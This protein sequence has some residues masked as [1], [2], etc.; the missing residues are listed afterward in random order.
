MAVSTQKTLVGWKAIAGYFSRDERTVM[1]WAASRGMPVQR[2]AGQARSSVYA[3]PDDLD[4]WLGRPQSTPVPDM[5]P[6]LPANLPTIEPPAA[7]PSA[8][9][10]LHLYLRR[11]TLLIVLLVCSI[12]V[13][14]AA[15]AIIRQQAVQA[16]VAAK[17]QATTPLFHDAEARASFLQATFDWNLRTRES[18][19]R[20][21]AEY[22]DAVTRDPGVAAS[23]VGIANS[24][25]L[26]R[27]YAEMPDDEAYAKAN[28][29]AKVAIGLDPRSMEARRSLAFIAFWWHGDIATAGRDFAEA[30]AIAPGDPLTHHWL[31][32]AMAAN[33]EGAAALR[34][35]GTARGL[36]PTSSSTM[37]D[38][39]VIAYLA[40][41][42]D[43]SARMFTMLRLADPQDAALH[44]ELGDIALFEGR[45]RDYLTET[46]RA[47][48]L[49]NDSEGKRRIAEQADDFA[50]AGAP[51]MFERMVDA[52]RDRTRRTN[53]GFFDFARVAAISGRTIAAIDALSPACTQHE[54]AAIA[55]PGDLWL[56]RAIPRG[57]V[58]RLCGRPSLESAVAA[59]RGTI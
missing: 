10:G 26:L 7:T 55:A 2:V 47:A 3:W 38:Y 30:I 59:A 16:D 51:F 31:A 12:M 40:G 5:P 22:G 21:I 32:T 41:H 54:P 17:P 11:G 4:A 8:N 9:R 15:W 56:S 29:A 19:F 28:A 43:E 25:L 50:H 14:V 6:P 1:R 13:A 23:Y 27:E 20:A 53:D 42:R 18:L 34:E 49:R 52:A 24:Y 44:R 35:I 45:Y 48:D 57:T 46:A 36:D 37:I 58:R 39:A 33:G